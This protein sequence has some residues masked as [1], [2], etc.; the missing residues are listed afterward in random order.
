MADCPLACSRPTTRQASAFRRIVLPT[1]FWVPKSWFRGVSPRMHS[2]RP[3]RSSVALNRRPSASSQFPASNQPFVV[4]VTTV[5]QFRLP[6]M[7]REPLWA[8]GATARRLPTCCAMASASA[9]SKGRAR[10]PPRPGPKPCPGRTMSRLLPR[11]AIRLVTSAVAPA[12]TVTMV[13]TAATPMMI[14][15]TVREERSTFRRISR[16]ARSRAFQRFMQRSGDARRT[17]GDHPGTA[18]SAGPRRPSPPRG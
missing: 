6:K 11:L 8:V 2:E 15:S 9:A 5:C 18:R 13:I 10:A 7:A 16:S 1:G 4:P 3:A 17:R 12:P 14:P